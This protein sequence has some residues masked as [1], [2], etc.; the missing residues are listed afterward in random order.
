MDT[1]IIFK[2]LKGAVTETGEPRSK[3]IQR[4]KKCEV[5]LLGMSFTVIERGYLAHC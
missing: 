3:T 5:S 4:K 2:N 1:E